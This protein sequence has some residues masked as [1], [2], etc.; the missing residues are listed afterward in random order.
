MSQF[1]STLFFLVTLLITH[2]L[3]AAPQTGPVI[4]GYGPVYGVAEGA[5]N[6]ETDR[7]YKVRMDVSVA[8]PKRDQ[9]NRNLESAARFLNMEARSGI[10]PAHIE[11]AIIVHGPAA[12][13]LLSDAAYSQLFETVNPNTALLNA[14][15]EAGV[16]IYLC[17]QTA[18]HRNISAQQLNPAVSLALSAMTAHVQLQEQGY[19]LIPF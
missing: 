10:D 12:Q 8:S 4:E 13:E 9:H 15:A 19:S 18:A 5:L 11:L 14:L 3:L 2:P 16:V 6:L 7:H 17:G 1:I